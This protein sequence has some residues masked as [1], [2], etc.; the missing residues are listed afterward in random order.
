[1]RWSEATRWHRASK[2]RWF[3]AVAPVAYETVRE[4]LA[5][6]D[7]GAL[8]RVS[9]QW[10]PC[11]CPTC[12]CCYCVS[13]WDTEIRFDDDFP[14]WYDATYGICPRGHRRLLND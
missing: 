12:K 3:E 7:A 14:S 9:R 6:A 1:M 4:A 10:A 13:H 8:H 5:A 11:Y 2:T